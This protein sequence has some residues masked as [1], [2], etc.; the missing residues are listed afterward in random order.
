MHFPFFLAAMVGILD[1][2]FDAVKDLDGVHTMRVGD[3][4][5]ALLPKYVR[6]LGLF[7]GVVQEPQYL[8]CLSMSDLQLLGRS[9]TF[10]EGAEFDQYVN[11]VGMAE[12]RRL[13]QM[14]T[15]GLDGANAE[16]EGRRKALCAGP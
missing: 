7:L 3:G 5:V 12:N 9:R 13:R 6:H 16:A 8:A 11:V 2:V 1:E 14:G 15:L 10:M 4:I